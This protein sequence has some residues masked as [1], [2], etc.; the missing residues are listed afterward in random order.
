MRARM[1]LVSAKIQC[2]VEEVDFKNKPERMLELSPKGTV[3]VLVMPDATVLEESLDIVYWA[4]EQ[5]DPDDLMIEGAKALIAE[6]DGDFKKALDR[7]KYPNR[8]PD[9]DCSGAQD[10]GTK[11]LEK[12]N[13][14]IV[15]NGQLLGDRV[16][17][18]DI[19]IFPFV[20]QFANVDRTYFDGLPLQ[21]LQKWLAD[22]LESP[23]FA[24]IIQKQDDTH[25]TLL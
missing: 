8:F 14:L 2:D 4:L 3:P 18:A 16:S 1:A 11:F 6:N 10:N 25:Y 24:H 9:E 15:Q 19:S 23:L 22:H 21:P 12:L 5:N 13:G 17:V 7:Y 20:R